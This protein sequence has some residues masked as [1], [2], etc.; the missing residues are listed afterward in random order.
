LE[1][2]KEKQYNGPLPVFSTLLLKKFYA[3][4]EKN[5]GKT[6]KLKLEYRCLSISIEICTKIRAEEF[7]QLFMK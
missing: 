4:K 6:D 7:Y 5:V 3:Y 2:T 1:I